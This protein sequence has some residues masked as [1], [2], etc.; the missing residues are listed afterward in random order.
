[1]PISQDKA[2]DESFSL[3]AL[4][5]RAV[6]LSPRISDAVLSLSG[7]LSREACDGDGEDWPR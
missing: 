3:R 1:M 4:A 7:R 6:F 5:G 2:R